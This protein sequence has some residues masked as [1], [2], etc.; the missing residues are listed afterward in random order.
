MRTS[1]TSPV[2]IADA[3]TYGRLVCIVG[4][5]GVFLESCWTKVHQAQGNMRLPMAAQI[6]GAFVNIVLDS[7]LI[8]GLGSIPAMDVAGAAWATVAGQVAAT[9]ITGWRGYRCPPRTQMAH[10][11]RK[12]YQLGYPS[13][14]CFDG[15]HT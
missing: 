8:F 7:L 14:G 12:I 6:V 15:L 1:A 3:I 4:S 11:A 5:I 13:V 2:A 10:Y 9:V